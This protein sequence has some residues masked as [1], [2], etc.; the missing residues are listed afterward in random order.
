MRISS[1]IGVLALLE[2]PL[3]PIEAP[4]LLEGPA[5]IEDP[6]AVGGAPSLQKGPLRY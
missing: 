4:W 3:T 2:G 5:L 1:L 6:L